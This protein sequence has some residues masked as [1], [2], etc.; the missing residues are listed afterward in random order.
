MKKLGRFLFF[1]IL[2]CTYFLYA[3]NDTLFKLDEVVVTEYKLKK[4]SKG[5]R[6][7][8]ITD[9]LIAGDKNSLTHVL[10]FNTPIYFKEYGNGMLSS[11]SFRGTSAAHTAV[12]WNGIN[13]NSQ[14]NGQTDFNTIAINNFNTVDVRSGGGSVLFGS[15]AIG[16]SIHLNNTVTFKKKNENILQLTAASYNTYNTNIAATRA[17]TQTFI[18]LGIHYLTAENNYPYLNSTLKNDNAAYNRNAFNGTFGIKIN[19]RNWLKLYSVT[20]INNR[21]I[22]RSLNAPS[23]SKLKNNTYRN[24][25]EWNSFFNNGKALTSRIAFLGEDYQYYENKFS[26]AYSKN[27]SRT[28]ITNIDY[29]QK[30]SDRLE[31]NT[32]LNYESVYGKGDNINNKFREVL[33]VVGVLNHSPLKRISYSAQIRKEFSSAYKIP[34]LYSLGTEIRLAKFYTL[35]LNVSKNFRVPTFNDLY[36]NGSGNLNLQPEKSYQ[37][38]IGNQFTFK[39]LSLSCSGFYIKSNNLIQWTPDINGIWKPDNIGNTK[40]YGL[41]TKLNIYKKFGK[42]FIRLH[43]NYSLTIAKDLEKNQNIIYVPKHKINALLD[44]RKGKFSS[45]YQFL[46]NGKVNVLSN[47]LP[48]YMVTNFGIDYQLYSSV[49]L[50]LKVNNLFNTAYQNYQYYPMPPRNYQIQIQI[51]I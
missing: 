45:H 42:H 29:Q 8:I 1:N 9:T 31:I 41:E 13:I 4:Y 36:W 18:N 2:F 20:T 26:D 14:L 17:T 19:H 22:A 50:G 15:G 38:E 6:V 33:S 5:Y 46:F 11:P 32:L 28:F 27:Q 24:L 10:Q 43:S 44:Y 3:Q 37:F 25:V 47:K 51:H 40:H 35:L 39:N 34:L 12:L 49:K 7:S 23:K 16:G 48:A 21:N 30:I